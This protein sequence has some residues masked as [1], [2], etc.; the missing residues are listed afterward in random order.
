MLNEISAG[1]ERRANELDRE[2]GTTPTCR[3]CT[4]LICERRCGC[5]IIRGPGMWGLIQWSW[6]IMI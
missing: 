2:H 5:A 4:A 1:A 6:I 3:I